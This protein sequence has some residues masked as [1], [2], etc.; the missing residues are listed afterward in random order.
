MHQVYTMETQL[1][2]KQLLDTYG[3]AVPTTVVHTHALVCSS[4]EM[5]GLL[6]V[7]EKFSVFIAW[8]DQGTSELETMLEYTI[9]QQISGLGVHTP[10]VESMVVQDHQT[11]HMVSPHRKSGTDVEEKCSGFMPEIKEQVLPSMLMMMSCSTMWEMDNGFHYCQ[12]RML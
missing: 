3:L 7:G 12:M 1:H 6:D 4:M 2:Y 11:G 9:L 10:T 5:T 8:M